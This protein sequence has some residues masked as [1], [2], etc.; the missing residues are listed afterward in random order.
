MFPTDLIAALYSLSIQY[1]TCVIQ[2]FISYQPQTGLNVD[3]PRQQFR[4]FKYTK[5]VLIK[6]AYI[7]KIYYNI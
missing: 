6:I 1:Y 2:L 7:L 4:R 3:F 5:F